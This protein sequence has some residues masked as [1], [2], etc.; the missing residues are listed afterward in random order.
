MSAGMEDGFLSDSAGAE[1]EALAKERALE[2]SRV[3]MPEWLARLPGTSAFTA[4][5]AV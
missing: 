4:D 3:G 5:P 1:H 2:R